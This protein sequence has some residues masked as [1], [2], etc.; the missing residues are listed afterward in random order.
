MW[1]HWQPVWVLMSIVYI[2]TG[3]NEVPLGFF[4]Y[5]IALVGIKCEMKSSC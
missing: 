2:F 1:V 3:E 5:T 4:Q